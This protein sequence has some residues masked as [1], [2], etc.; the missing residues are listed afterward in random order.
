MA[1]SLLVVFGLILV[2]PA[3]GERA[4]GAPGV[5]AAE[6]IAVLGDWLQLYFQGKLDL[7]GSKQRLRG[8]NAPMRAKDFVSITSGLFPDQDPERWSHEAELEKLCGVVA[9]LNTAASAK[10]LLEVAAV[11]LDQREYSAPMNPVLVRQTAEKHLASLPAE[12]R[13]PVLD[14]ASAAA[15]GVP[16]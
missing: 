13:Q 12:G 5:A 9:A 7:T 3:P 11:G 2:L 16:L 10:S 15:T 8:R 6:P 4:G 14:L 1:P